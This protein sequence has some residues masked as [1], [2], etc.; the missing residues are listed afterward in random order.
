[1]SA[2]DEATGAAS[3]FEAALV[4]VTR[5]LAAFAAACIALMAGLTTLAVIMRYFVG[6]PLRL[7][8]D[9][10]GLL[11]IAAIF[12]SLPHALVT[13]AHIR[14]TLL[15]E[16]TTGVVRRALW[17]AAQAVLVAFAA[18]F[19]YAGWGEAAFTLRFGLRSEIARLPLAP[20]VLVMLVGMALTGAIAVWQ[21]LKAPPAPRRTGIH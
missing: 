3:G 2:Q 14:V 6:S 16:R 5:L 8:E 10:S 4:L 19:V 13:H 15:S 20:F 7:T 9:L 11:L 18:L 17:I 21:A 12:L 1:M